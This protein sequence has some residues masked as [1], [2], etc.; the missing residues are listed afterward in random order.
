ML[1]VHPA[2][3]AATT[4]R[5]FFIHIA[6]IVLGLC[7]AVGLEQTVELI[8]HRHQRHQLQE[9]LHGEALANPVAEY[10]LAS[11]DRDMSWLLELRS[12]VDAVRLGADRMQFVYPTRPHGY[13]GDPH[14]RDRFRPFNAVWNTGRRT[15]LVDLLPRVE[16]QLYTGF[17][18]NIDTSVAQLDQYAALIAGVFMNAQDVKRRLQIQMAWNESAIDLRSPP[19]ISE[20]LKAHPDPL[21]AFTPSASH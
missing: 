1:D 12:R 20:Y 2:H 18:G 15:G 5:D 6:T 3:H 21:P 17:Y 10:N 14:E 9:D 19:D 16:A 7:I 11:L 4:W 8:H 13:P